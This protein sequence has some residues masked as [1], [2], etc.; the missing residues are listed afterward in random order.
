M[1]VSGLA[2]G[3]REHAVFVVA[4]DDGITFEVADAGAVRGGCGALRDVAF[5]GDPRRVI[6]AVPL[7]ALRACTTQKPVQRAAAQHVVPHVTVD[8]LVA[9]VKQSLP[10]EPARDLFRTPELLELLT[11]EG[12]VLLGELPVTPRT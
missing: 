11:N 6:G 9:D 10:F 12:P 4:A 7:A 5:A 8:G 2:I 1:N 3:Y